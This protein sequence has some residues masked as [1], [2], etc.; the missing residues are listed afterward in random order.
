MLRPNRA[1]S[2][3]PAGKPVP[4]GNAAPYAAGDRERGRNARRHADLPDVLDALSVRYVILD[5]KSD[6]DL[7]QIMQSQ[8]RWLVDFEDGEGAI[9]SRTSGE[10]GPER[11]FRPP[12]PVK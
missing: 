9:F 5:L 2:T 1:G 11:E 7:H 12:A 6:G 8:P 3:S 4:A 10:L